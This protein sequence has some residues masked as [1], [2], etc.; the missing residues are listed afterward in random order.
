MQLQYCFQYFDI[1]YLVVQSVLVSVFWHKL[2][3]MLKCLKIRWKFPE[4]QIDE[5]RHHECGPLNLSPDYEI[6]KAEGRMMVSLLLDITQ[7]YTVY[8]PSVKTRIISSIYLKL[9]CVWSAETNGYEWWHHGEVY[10]N[11]SLNYKKAFDKS[12]SSPL[13]EVIVGPSWQ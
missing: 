8:L 9:W 4:P 11:L 6:M 5:L 2:S 7:V 3:I 13:H 12:T 1:N 10:S